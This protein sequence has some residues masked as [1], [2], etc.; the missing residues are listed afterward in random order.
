[1]V[2]DRDSERSKGFITLDTPAGL[3]VQLT[4]YD[5]VLTSG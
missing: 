4:E 2:F 1:M 5:P 3:I